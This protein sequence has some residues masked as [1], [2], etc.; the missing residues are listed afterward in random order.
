MREVALTL[1]RRLSEHDG[2]LLRGQQ[3]RAK[4]IGMKR[5]KVMNIERAEYWSRI[6]QSDMGSHL[7]GISQLSKKL[8]T[9][10]SNSKNL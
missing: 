9:K 6:T 4:K 3:K 10:L 7:G 2:Y 5:H 1:K 8:Y